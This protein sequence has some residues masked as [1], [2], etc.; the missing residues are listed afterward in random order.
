MAEIDPES[1]LLIFQLLSDGL[2]SAE[3]S[4]DKMVQMD[5]ALGTDSEPELVHSTIDTSADLDVSYIAQIARDRALAQKFAAEEQKYRLDV[6]FA[7][8]LADQGVN[9]TDTCDADR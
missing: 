9:A 6:E 3:D 2:N 5:H 8:R 7:R 1:E 4:K